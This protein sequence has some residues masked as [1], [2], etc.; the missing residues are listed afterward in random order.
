M[1]EIKCKKQIKEMCVDKGTM[2]RWKIC[3]W[4]KEISVSER[5]YVNEED[6]CEWKRWIWWD[7]RLPM[8][9]IKSKREK[10]WVRRFNICFFRFKIS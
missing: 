1:N 8:I 4:M 5:D 6:E 10:V 3:V 9:Y 2:D 7:L